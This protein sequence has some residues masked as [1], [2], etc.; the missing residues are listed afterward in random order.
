MQQGLVDTSRI[1]DDDF[2]TIN[3]KYGFE[4]AAFYKKPYSIRIS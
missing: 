2:L 4:G 1:D 3:L